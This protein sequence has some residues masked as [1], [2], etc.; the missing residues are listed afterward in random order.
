MIEIR[1]QQA[2]DWQDVYAIRTATLSALPYIRPDWV[3][4]ELAQ[5]QESHWPL[6][7]VAH[8]PDGPKVVARVDLELGRGRLSH[9]AR[10]TFEQHPDLGNEAGPKLLQETVKVAENWWNRRRLEATL[11]VT[12]AGAITLFESLGFVQEARLRQG[13]RIAGDLVDE[14][15]L[16]RLSGDALQPAT[17]ATLPPTSL[18]DRS[19]ARPRV[20]I[21]GGSGD[22]WEAFHVIFSQPSVYWGTMQIP[23]PSA[24]W[25]RERVQH[26]PPPRFWPLVAQVDGQVVGNLGLTRDE[27]NRSHVGHL[28]MMVHHDYQGMGIGS[29]LMEAAIDLTENWLGLTRL[30]LEVHRDN[31]RAIGLY[32]KYGFEREGL[33]RAFAYRDGQYVDTLVM[34]RL[35]W[36]T[37]GSMS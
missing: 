31:A 37:G 5:P 29:T 7:A 28:G 9:C 18:A 34:G 15:V 11:P 33:Y 26:R 4:Q 2:T 24:D 25:N 30:Q 1:G 6:V 36:A 14:V 8:L 12:G 16:A 13:V 21:R 10:L 3:K 27:H 32:E 17:P 22:D 35:R 20:T 19:P 23:Y